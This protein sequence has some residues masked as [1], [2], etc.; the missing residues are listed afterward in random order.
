MLSSLARSGALLLAFVALCSSRQV[1]DDDFSLS[2]LEQR[3]AEEL[4]L[5]PGEFVK[6]EDESPENFYH[7][8]T[9]RRWLR[10]LL[11]DRS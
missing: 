7:F 8:V 3:E 4:G 11:Y 5:S 10:C 1:L 6:R 9:V 2:I